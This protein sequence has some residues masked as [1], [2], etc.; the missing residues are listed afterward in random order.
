MVY[1]INGI[2]SN[3]YWQHKI[4]VGIKTDKHVCWILTVYYVEKEKQKKS[5][6]EQN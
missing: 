1:Y 5:C 2:E 6:T 4:T 3:T